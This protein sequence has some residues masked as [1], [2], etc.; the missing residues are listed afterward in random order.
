MSTE[1]LSA[2]NAEFESLDWLDS[3]AGEMISLVERLCDLNSGSTNLVGLERVADILVDEFSGISH[4]VE[5]LELDRWKR[6]DDSG[7]QTEVK[8][9][10]ALRFQHQI[11][12]ERKVWLGIHYDT[13]YGPAHPFQRCHW[14]DEQI[15]RGP[16]VADAKGG[17]VV[18]LFALRAVSRC[19]RSNEVGW[20]V[21]LNPDEE[22][23]SPGASSYFQRCAP[24]FDFGMLFEPALPD[25]SLAFQRKGSGNFSIVVRGKS[26]HAGRDF[27]AGRNAMVRI[28]KLAA[29]LDELNGKF[30]DSTLNIGQI[31]GGGPTNVV[32]DFG[33]ARL[34]V[35]VDCPDHQESL[36]A[37][38]R[39]M[40]KAING[41]DG[42]SCEIYGEINA[43]PKVP[44]FAIGQMRQWVERVGGF[45]G[46]KITWADTGGV[47]DGNKLFAAGL[48]N[49]DTL[50]PKGG[51]IHSSREFLDVTSL[52]PRAKLAA[53][54]MLVHGLSPDGLLAST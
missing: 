50:G 54:M 1:D 23:G 51:E 14:V 45:V 27:H 44:D 31:L 38:M 6:V 39:Q 29:K 17:I 8:L 18:L 12:A 19:L 21:F 32:P 52:V 37:T 40:A 28:S 9:G 30:G 43:P 26:A 25:G 20:E 34:N 10:H 13:V 16:G 7:N 33:M 49:L 41:E 35:R 22:L 48:P 36:V 4:T 2:W 46:E 5:K 24:N 15:L 42:F 11:E 47:C 53:G 3:Q